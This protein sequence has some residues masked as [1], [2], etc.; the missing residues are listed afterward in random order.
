MSAHSSEDDDDDD[1]NYVNL[2]H[3]QTTEKRLQISANGDAII[4]RRRGGSANSM[5]RC[6]RNLYLLWLRYPELVLCSLLWSL[7]NG[8][9]IF[10]AMYKY[11]Y[12]DDNEHFF[13]LLGYGISIAKA[14]SYVLRFNVSLSLAMVCRRFWSAVRG[15]HCCARYMSDRVVDYH[16]WLGWTIFAA[17]IVHFG[18]H[19]YNFSELASS[20]T[21][22]QLNALLDEDLS[23][24]SVA[25]L[26]FSTMT[27]ATGFALLLVTVALCMATFLRR[28]A[29]HWFHYSHLLYVPF[30]ALALVHGTAEW[31]EATQMLWWLAAPGLVWL[32]EW[33]LTQARRTQ[34]AH[35]LDATELA[36]DVLLLRLAKPRWFA[37]SAGQYVNLS[38]PGV[39]PLEWHPY[40]LSSVASEPDLLVHVK[41]V[42]DWSRKLRRR[43]LAAP[44][45]RPLLFV[46][47]PFRSP[48]AAVYQYKRVV[49][50][51]GG[52]GVT[53][54][55]AQ[56]KALQCH[57][58]HASTVAFG[59]PRRVLT[60]Q[61][62]FYWMVR[63]DDQYEW[64][65]DTLDSVA[66][67][68]AL[69][70]RLHVHH[71]ITA[72]NSKCRRATSIAAAAQR[73]T[74]R[75][76]D[77]APTAALDVGA[78]D[79][80]N[81]NDEQQTEALRTLVGDYRSFGRPDFE[82]I[83]DSVVRRHRH[84][85]IAVFFCGPVAVANIIGR[86]CAQINATGIAR[87]HYIKELF[88]S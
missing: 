3:R 78:D 1:N 68:D 83:L 8:A 23:S 84:Q 76:A 14:A 40:S 16:R 30:Y 20:L 45:D 36:G 53:P 48:A 15:W 35:V 26:L 74:E 19:M 25:S 39:Q 4:R 49:L 59:S 57:W 28:L 46:D 38:M 47:G 50:I 87:L 37:Y 58:S 60:E 82:F 7:A 5:N 62:Y 52:I 33:T 51:G 66:A 80:A 24:A 85:R 73:Y 56:L 32:A 42:G 86:L 41:V 88:L 29:Y 77:A 17:G 18:A 22:A 13:S 34:R 63:N 69:Q 70:E 75:H 61:V 43:M 71:Y 12:S 6:A 65:A 44:R 31:F 64:F 72:G 67:D 54:F 55:I 27:G 21:T 2:D 9:L 11:Q 10:Y 79:G 81:P